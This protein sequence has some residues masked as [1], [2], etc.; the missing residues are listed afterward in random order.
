MTSE[1]RMQGS[2]YP[3]KE[4]LYT[5]RDTFRR[6][7]KVSKKLEEESQHECSFILESNV[8][9]YW[10]R[11]LARRGYSITGSIDDCT[12]KAKIKNFN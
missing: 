1:I 10:N 7:A 8:L 4:E 12:E 3:D 2:N 5:N 6:W 9:S 11:V